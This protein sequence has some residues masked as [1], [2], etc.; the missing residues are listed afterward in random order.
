[1]ITAGT[2]KVVGVLSRGADAGSRC[3]EAVYERVDA[4][5]P[6]IVATAKDAAT[7]GGYTLPEWAGG[8]PAAKD[9]GAPEQSSSGDPGSEQPAAAPP[10]TSSGSKGGCSTAP[11]SREIPL[12]AVLLVALV[13]LR[14]K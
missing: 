12:F 8:P 4:F 13:L 11:Q 6:L 2:P 7:A 1:S 10:E 14:R 5:A 9:A 3:A